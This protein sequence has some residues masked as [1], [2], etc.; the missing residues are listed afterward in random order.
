[1]SS[2]L[3]VEARAL[4]KTYVQGEARFAALDG[5]DLRIGRGEFVCLM[6]KSGSGKSTLLHLIGGLEK[7]DSGELRIEGQELSAYSDDALSRFRR[8]RLGFVFQFFNLIPT[9]S[10]LENAALPRLL[11]GEGLAKVEGKARELL[12]R[13]DLGHRLDHKPNQLSGGEMQRVAIA[14]ALISDPAL[15]LADEPTGA[16]DTKT[17]DS[18]LQLLRTLATE[19]GQSILMV[20]HDPKAASFGSRLVRMQDGRLAES[21]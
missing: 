18:V 7:V 19:N 12:K 16:L 2:E 20:T 17:S 15:I 5:V 9:L 10:A 4:R 8:T 14:R 6:G 11:E 13:M 1:M 3:V 21:P